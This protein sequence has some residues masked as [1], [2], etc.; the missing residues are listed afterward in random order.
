MCATSTASSGGTALPIFQS[1]IFALAAGE[2][3]ADERLHERVGREPVRAVKPG[4]GALAH[5]REP[6]NGGAPVRR[7]LDSAAGIVGRRDDR[8]EVRRHVDAELH[9]FL[10]D[11]RESLHEVGP[12][13]LADVEEHA[14]VA[15]SLHL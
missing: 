10:V 7:R 1:G 8:Y 4:A 14:V 13:L 5:G 6:P 2:P 12:A 3:R 9:A 15:G 11:V